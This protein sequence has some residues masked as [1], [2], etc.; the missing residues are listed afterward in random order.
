MQF[1]SLVT[2]LSCQLA[3]GSALSIPFSSETK[4]IKRDQTDAT[5]YAYGTN[6]SGW[7]VSYN[8]IDKLLYIAS[9]ANDTTAGLTP[10]TWD[11]ASITSENWQMNGTLS[12]GTSAGSLYIL[13]EAFNAV[14][15]RD[16]AGITELNGTTTGFGLFA[17]QLVYNNDSNLESQFWAQ[18][19]EMEGI[20]VLMWN[21]AGD[22]QDDSFPVTVKASEGS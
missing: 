5:L 11:I 7:P 3:T 8:P 12:N 18:S 6:S 9:N 16:D 22:L 17:T 2:L 10:I 19:T 14:G 20:Y 15:V 13:P 1:L 21:T 4:A